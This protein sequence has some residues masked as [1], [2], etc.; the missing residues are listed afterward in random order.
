MNAMLKKDKRKLLILLVF[1]L[2]LILTA[3]LLL[4]R[5]KPHFNYLD[6]YTGKV[7]VL[8]Q[9]NISEPAEIKKKLFL[10]DKVKTREQS[11]AYIQFGED[12]LIKV[13][14]NTE[15]EMITLP[16][17][18]NSSDE[19]TTLNII[20][21]KISINAGKLTPGGKLNIQSG[22]GIIAVRGTIFSVE[23]E[24]D[25]LKVEV[26]ER[27]VSIAPG[28]GSEE[29]ILSAGEKVAQSGSETKKEKMNSDDDQT[30]ENIGRLRPIINIESASDEYI[31]KYFSK[32]PA[33]DKKN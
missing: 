1:L 16:G 15:L 7:E 12:H 26:K 24:G 5:E 27:K 13:N 20:K 31:E 14:Q 30:F 6:F 9:D 19:E 18:I 17:K 3:I 10:S 29:I 4:N 11:Q 8:K 33:Q 32:K 25:I 22:M 28:A 23:R 21:G 2:F